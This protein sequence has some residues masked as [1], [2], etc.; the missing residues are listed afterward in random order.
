MPLPSAPAEWVIAPPEAAMVTAPV[1]KLSANTPVPP[2]PTMTLFL[3]VTL[4][5]PF[6]LSAPTPSA[7]VPPVT[8]PAAMTVTLLLVDV[9]AATA[10]MPLPLPVTAPAASTTTGPL[11][12]VSDRATMPAPLVPFTRPVPV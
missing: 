1:P 3:V 10:V 2:S 12:P 4:I 9:P 7:P 11:F 5:A 6:W 8:T